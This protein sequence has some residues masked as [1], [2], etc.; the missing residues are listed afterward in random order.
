MT[1]IPA[2]LRRVAAALA[3]LL[4][5]TAAFASG[6]LV[7]QGRG[8]ERPTPVRLA[9][10]GLGSGLSCD[11]LR[12]W[13]VDRALDRVTAWGWG[14]RLVYAAGG[15]PAAGDAVSPAPRTATTPS[16][17]SATGTNVQESDVDEPDVVKTSGTLLVRVVDDT[18]TTYDV[19]GP[20]P[21]MLGS[22]PLTGLTDPQLL[23]A[24]DRVVALGTATPSPVAGA[25]AGAGA[26]NGPAPVLT[27]VRTFDVS[28]PTRP[29]EVD[30]RA[31]DG[32]L[33]TA[34]QTG[35]VI[36][37]VLSSSLPSLR[38]EMPEPTR[39]EASALR[40]NRALVRHTTIADWLPT[41]T[42]GSGRSRPSVACSDVAVPDDDAGP[43]TLTVVGFRAA[44]PEDTDTT[45]VATSSDVAYLSTDL[46]AVA[47]SPHPAFTCC[48]ERP[49]PGA[50]VAPD[51]A[52]QPEP[53]QADVR[54]R[55][56]AFALS[57]TSATYVGNAAVD[58]QVANSWA[59][60]EHDGVLRVAVGAAYGRSSSAVVL[61]RPEAGRLVEV[62]RLDGLGPDQQLRSVRWLGDT[63]VM[64]T[65][66]QVDP[67][68]V[69]D[70]ADPTRPQVLGALHL[71]GWSSYLHP[72]GPHLLLGLGQT[73][74]R[75]TVAPIPIPTPLP[76]PD[77]SVTA[78]P[79]SLA[80]SR[81]KATLFDISDPAHPRAR[82]TVDYPAGTIAQAG[83]QPHQVTW[84]PATRTLL[85]V[86]SDG[87]G[88][89][90]W[91]SVLTV[92]D[93]SL[94][95]RL[96]PLAA[97]GDVAGVRTVPLADGRVVLVAGDS[98]RFL[99]L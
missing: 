76:K 20:H 51:V 11:A 37:L 79:S 40:A 28:D 8:T 80:E 64:V 41:V 29:T 87:Y 27:R 94:H 9:A 57:G 58:G 78:Q 4:A 46:L 34:R 30:S 59:M 2:A 12:Q 5:V 23:L 75:I 56:Y 70:L 93:G 19:S 52:R 99:S 85:T 36:R 45:A 84:L 1:M 95:D 90:V 66:R 31:Y 24:G 13:Y 96:V 18:L 82:G 71:P 48:W 39:T 83:M 35:D 86:V 44:A 72:V 63:A 22:A 49:M 74:P 73:S 3:A 97:P 26:T 55:L 50:E 77:S 60:D 67:F 21:R 25:D 7:A 14:P 17:T 10:A 88:G 33:V 68:Y 43:G 81:A 65:Y 92:G 54:T 16:T 53:R 32:V 47:A 62:G 15:V 6:F 91:V 38:F 61:L 42:D 89:R 98:V 69:L